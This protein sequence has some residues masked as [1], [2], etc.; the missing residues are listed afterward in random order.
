[1]EFECKTKWKGLEKRG[2]G[3]RLLRRGSAAQV[4]SGSKPELREGCRSIPSLACALLGF[5]LLARDPRENCAW[6]V[7]HQ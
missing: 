6:S 4:L 5:L 2:D 7:A 3:K 1:M